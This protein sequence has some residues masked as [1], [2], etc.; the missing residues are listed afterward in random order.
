MKNFT[1]RSSAILIFLACFGFLF[2]SNDA[3]A[4]PANNL[5]SGAIPLTVNGAC[6]S[7]T[8]VAATTTPATDGAIGCWATAASNTVWFQF[9]T[10]AT[11]QTY[12]IST[13][14]GG[15]TDT[16][17]K[18]FTSAC[19]GTLAPA[20][21]CNED[22]GASGTN[23]LAAVI[24][25]SALAPSTTYYIEIDVYGGTTGTFCISV[26]TLPDVC[27]NAITLTAG[28]GCV[29]GSNTGATIAGDGAGVGAASCWTG[30]NAYSNS[31]FYNFVAT[32]DSMTVSF[33][34]GSL[35]ANAYGP[36]AAIY[37]GSCGSL[38]QLPPTS[39]VQDGNDINV[40]GLTVGNTY[41]VMVDG[42]ALNTGSYCISVSSTLPGN[43]N[44]VPLINTS[45][46][47]LNFTQASARVTSR[48]TGLAGTGLPCTLNITGIPA[49]C[50]VIQKAYLFYEMSYTS[51]APVTS[52][53]VSVTNPAAALFN[54]NA[55]LVGRSHQKCWGEMG[56]AS[57]RTDVTTAI[58]GNGNYII[59]TALTANEIDGMTLLI[60]YRDVNATYEGHLLIDNGIITINSFAAAVA[61]HTITGVN[62]CAA[63]AG[64]SFLIAG[65]F[66]FATHTNTITG[67]ST[68]VPVDNFWNFDQVA[69]NYTLGQP[70]IS[71][72][73]TSN[74]VV[75][76]D[77]FSLVATG[78]YY[79]T[80][81]CTTCN[82]PLTVSITP[83]Q[84]TCGLNNGAATANPSTGIYAPY[85][86]AWSPGGMST[87]TVT[88]LAP[89][90]YT[91]TVTDPSG[92]KTATQTVTINSSSPATASIS[93]ASASICNGSS[94]TLT[95]SGGGLYSWSSGQSTAA[96]TVSPA[97]TTGY[98][99]TVTVG[100]CTATAAATVTVTQPAVAT[101][102]YTGTPYCQN[103]ANPSPTFSGG[104]VAGT[105]SSSAGLVF[106]STA[107]GQV[108][109]SAST[110]GTY[111]VTNTIPASGPCPAVTATSTITITPLPVATFSY[112]GSPYCKNAANPSP[113]FSGGGVAGTFSSTA[114]LVF[115]STATGQVNLAA[116]TA[117]T[118]TV[119]NTI[120]ASGGCPAVTATATITIT[121][122]P[123]ATFSYTASPYCQSA[124]NPSPT[125]S[126]GG[127]AGTFSS[128]AG[129]VFVS[130]S[131][132]QVNLSA[133]TPGTY[134]VTN[135]IAPSGGCPATT[136]TAAITIT[137]LPVATFSYTASPY[138]Q[139]AANPSP[140]FSGGGTAGVFSS[141]AGLVFVS[142]ST[143]QVNLSASTVG[144][145]TVTNMIAASGGCPAVTATATI[146][147]T[148]LPVAAFSYAASPYCQSAAN[149]SPAFSGGGTAGTFSSTAGL[150]FVSTSTGQVN[151]S[152]STPGTYTVTNTIAAASGCPAV[153][154][155]TTITITPAPVAAFSYTA[156]PY[157]QNAANPSPAFSG[158]GSAGTFS[159]TA[160]LVF[161]STSTGQ[162]NLSASTPGTYTVTNT[163]A[164]SGGCPAATATASITITPLPVATF[165]YTG[166]PYCQN[167]ANPSP[168]FSGGGVAGTFSSTAGLS[169]NA[170]TGLVNL[171]A[172]TPGT[173]TVTNTI[174][175]ASGC[176]A[177]TATATITITPLQNASF[178]YSS[179]TYCQTGANP[180][181]TITGAAGGTFSSS[182]AG[183]VFISTST[184]QINL[185][186]SALNT[187]T[188]TYTTAGPC[189]N[190]STVN[191]TISNA[192]SASFSYTGSPY[193]QNGTNPFPTFSGGGTAGTFSSTAGLV[194]VNTGT[195]QVDL[196]ASTAGTYTVT[197]TIAASGGCAAASAT[198][199]ITINSAPAATFS[200]TA[201]PYCQNAANPSPTFSGGGTAGT[202]SSA[203]GLSINAATGVI[204]LAASTP[205]T[206]TVTNT[207]AASGACPAVTATASI[208]ITPLPVATFTYTGSP[209]CQN[210][211]NPSPTFSGGGTAGTFT[212][213]A[214]LVINAATGAVNLA[215]STA[216]TY[217][218]TNTIA[219]SGGC[220]AVTATASITIT[221]V[222]VAAFS[223][224][225]SPYCQN[226]A[227][228]SPTFSG[229]GTAGTFSSTAGLV[230]V[231]T[232]T[233]QVNLSASTP[234]TYT[235]TNTIAA[236][237]G[238]PATSATASITITPL[239][240][241]T[242]SYAASPY[243]QSAANPSPAFSGGGVAG[244]FSS[245]AG[246][247]FVSSGTGQVNLSASTP[248]TYTVTNTVAA[249]GGC[250]AVTAT[251]TI[252]ITP[253]PVA[254]FSYTAS[255]YCQGAA[256][257]SPTFSGGGVAGTFSSTAGL[258][259]VSSSTGQVN[260]SASTP[261]TYTVTNTIA[262]SGG[263]PSTAATA[264]ITINASPTAA[265][266][267][268]A[269]P[270]CQN[271]A[272]PSPTFS[273]GGIAGTFSSTAGLVFVS[274]STG[275]VNLSA[276]TPGTYTVTNTLPASGGCPAITATAGITINPVQN[277]AFSYSGSTF[278]SSGTNPVPSI[279]GTAGGTFSASPAGLGF[280]STSTGEINLASSAL[281]TYT[282]TYTTPGPCAS[283]ATATI[284]ISNAPVATFSYSGSPY[285]QNGTD[286][287][288]AFSGGGTAG[289]F[290]SA[291]GLSINAANGTVNLAASTPG[292]YTVTNTIPASGG[293][294]AATATASITINPVQ[295]A[296]FSYSSPTFCQ[297]GA[298]P[299]PT[300][301]G[302]AGGTFS[303]APAGLVF[304]ST[305]SGEINL[306][307]SG[308][309]T[310]TITY[311]TPGPCPSSATASVT[312]SNPTLATINY[313]GPYCQD[314]ADPS[315]NFAAGASAGAFTASPAGLV[316]V[317]TST[318]Q[319]DLS[320]STA[321]TYTVT[322][323]I[324]ASGGCPA[325]T[326][327]ASVTITAPAVAS[328]SYA[329]SPYCQSAANPSPAFSGGGIAGT[330]TPSSPSLVFVSPSTG[331]IDL[332]ASTP[333]TYTVTNTIPASGGCPAVTATANVT[334][335]APQTAGFSYTGSPYCQNAS[336]PLPTFTGSSVAG[337][338]SAPAGL[339]FTSTATG[340][341]NLAAST[342]G[343]YTVTNTIPAS[344]GCPAVAATSTITI[345]P[346]QTAAFSYSGS[347]FCVS[348]TNPTPTITG[349]TGGTFTSSPAGLSFVS[350]ATGEINLASTALNTYTITYTTAGPCAAA[351]SVSVT[352]TNAPNATFSYAASPYCQSAADPAP[353]FGAGASGG[354]F[355]ST[356]G[357]MINAGTGIVDLSAST[358][359]TYTVTNTIAASG[360]C[361]AASATASITISPSQNAG[362]S[363]S[364]ATF[365]SSGANPSPTITGVAG[366]SFTSSP[367]GLSFVSTAT[368]QI[369]LAGS[370]LNTYT[371]T[372]TTPGPCA[373]SSAVSITIT[374]AP[375]ATFSYTGTP[376][377]AGG[378]NP[379]PTFSG[380]GTAGIFSSTAG[381]VFVNTSTGE[382]DLTAS[383]P[384]T[385]TVT[386]TIAASGGCAA[387][388]A[389]A[390]ITINPLQ[391]AAF[392]Y[393]GS[394]F[395]SS[396]TNPVATITGAPGGTFS[397][398]PAGLVFV[399]TATG[400][401][402][403]AGSAL[404]TYTVTYTTPGPCANTSTASVTIT[405]SPAAT[406]SYTASPYCQGGTNPSPT[407]SG[408]GSAG[409]FTASPAGLSINASSGLVDL[410]ASTPGTYTVT[411]TIAASGGC[412]AA[413]ATAGITI[414]APQAATF[415]YTA[416]PYCQSG[417][418]PSPTFSGGGVA[419]TFTASPSGLSINA[420]S[421]LVNLASSTAGTY[422]VT[423]TI[424]ATGGCPAVTAIASIT[425]NPLQNAA[426]S[427]SAASF[428]QSSA[429][430]TPTI[431]GVA[432]GTFTASPSG[433][434]INAGTGSIA[435]SS[436]TVNT[437]TITYTT[438]GPCAS[439]STATVA[440]TTAPVAAATATASVCA[441]QTV[442]FTSSG[443]GTYSWTGPGFSSA[444]Q[445]PVISPAD[446]SNSGTYTVT[447][448]S[449][450]CSDTAQVSVIV[451]PLPATNAGPDVTITQGAG[452][453]L[454][455]SGGSSYTW[456]PAATLSCS[457]CPA[458]VA[459]PSVTTT[460]CVT[461]SSGGCSDNDCVTVTVEI[462][463]NTNKELGVPN[464]F[465]PNNDGNNDLFCLQ[466][467]SACMNEFSILIYD[468]WGEKVY[469]GGEADFCWDG[470]FR[471]KI[472]DP[473][474]FVYFIKATYTTGEKVV[475][476][477][478]ISIIR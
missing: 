33:G 165:S 290:T 159:S 400:E 184:G 202:F 269:S 8:N 35:L 200:Y 127:V 189:A 235:V 209:Y 102:S 243:C 405:T 95:A 150:V 132:G 283:S 331:Q 158:G 91:V 461:T 31:V 11:P 140:T 474:V 323:T 385:Y 425:I 453:N 250:P 446:V 300:I 10:A 365:C 346:A 264:S 429:N 266:S 230:F 92:C 361:A 257:P 381:L 195:G 44:L 295:S 149:P 182:P 327:T 419:G 413:S 403:L 156:S 316:F 301:T 350:T 64:T 293:C 280:V 237:G 344:G 355:S 340:E 315:P 9:T 167:A 292:T 465:S 372:Y 412:P 166:S 281:N 448:N 440:V 228:P 478:N 248:G 84:P 277:A 115:V 393:S 130:T 367:A 329:G 436:S 276:S 78:A 428:C 114:G 343:T 330:F 366:G 219:A 442:S 457:N 63:S 473:A 267:Y 271:A 262:A 69:T 388:T 50:R 455:A 373:D 433:L 445:N 313:N 71:Y 437:Y 308:L 164:A 89:G 194:F 7:G 96:I 75:T 16:E 179:G 336:N 193:C 464:A 111:T 211:A 29:N 390:G 85:T 395:C 356:A 274:T 326:D 213:S 285:C 309:N 296:A 348:G 42:N 47:G 67:A 229:G 409:T 154:A 234:G 93:P 94:T 88:G 342:A 341:V 98:T 24:V 105:F 422:T 2:Y 34:N 463:C 289:T 414:N 125:F 224:T 328:F 399:S 37:S 305:A 431:T 104:G 100:T 185:S 450:G 383:T 389:T 198:A 256:N 86:Y 321:G 299:T 46:C 426:F 124:A 87:Q 337:T 462:P 470:T 128:T 434:S 259:F 116:S 245:T 408:G 117:G 62:A 52:P 119:T 131:T 380:G 312:V 416:S 439:S 396:G 339:V 108:N 307:A 303:S 147:I 76:S 205:G 221:T 36:Y 32:N 22:V 133:S 17:M 112:T 177:V 475:K 173:Y 160:G 54:Y 378:T 232:S 410:A 374:N 471:G 129:L 137:P 196:A 186:A 318:G 21:N 302:A 291:A 170:S 427:Y 168:A 284:S 231:S 83:T 197:N 157:C 151:L 459:T 191:V 320:A 79:Q 207:I 81:T 242:F 223:Y 49:T 444:S 162:V 70:S 145:Y 394:T 214:G 215:A 101:F 387:A 466:G 190:S 306:A 136:A 432:G 452:T 208:T 187:Y 204:N 80:T 354:V 103:A 268:T 273:G 25:T 451:N 40:T 174:P 261:G 371:I 152:A 23:T 324:A 404:N 263:C 18:L 199:S 236:S 477:G 61:S 74:Y 169:I 15:S 153:T 297:T 110:P 260:L 334:I 120:A 126:G 352:V 449:G 65:D 217:T 282:I 73:T 26:S 317:S 203:A 398:A 476:K 357:L 397:A 407:Y 376:Y 6:T 240:A 66:Q 332:A 218:V 247:V 176:P 220:P 265:F 382:V 252:T 48:Y 113:T 438:P 135:T 77:C 38:S 53:T 30:A 441:G 472:L 43:N 212:S 19:T 322:N 368:G 5:C 401:I 406:F 90:T 39:C 51:N 45:G 68:A 310:Y 238:C 338:F 377:C 57:Y 14:N 423:N 370:A 456:T 375:V 469:E 142:T 319:V 447:V 443:G 27:A 435:L 206:Y 325:S 60:I 141:T 134:T 467:W 454:A 345:N 314:A 251:A 392:S 275:Q 255:P 155:T 364:S 349:T 181:P 421:G 391:N 333:G 161:V 143:G 246:L 106:V 122:L 227:N 226:A 148:P 458:P 359:G 278:C 304:V 41:Y 402:N 288:P 418:N 4:Q 222:P 172:S 216:G 384:G 59:N 272:N 175:A 1:P 424:A 415:S 335:T 353:V 279:T 362:F 210:A 97:A 386:N 56:T 180:T 379:L 249:S 188:I 294:A 420:S 258:V 244:T 107:T 270:Y 298:N 146:T 3:F 28:A 138:C 369:N 351:S 82:L 123:V 430:P 241:A 347:T 12:V 55:T 286:P 253:V 358:P 118:Y 178:N 460:Y 58:T 139:N 99:V 121:P 183:L 72:S 411:N 311:T 201:S 109:L 233:G 287:S 192:P 254:A 144:T 13:D 20:P 171:A 360:G 468:R 417:T 225:A 239:P 163:I 363:Y